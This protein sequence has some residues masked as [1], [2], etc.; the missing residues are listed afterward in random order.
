M[1]LNTVN[2]RL[3]PLRLGFLVKP[4]DGRSLRNA[5]Q[6]NTCLWGGSYNP[7]VPAYTRLTKK[8]KGNYSYT[9]STR[10]IVQGFI[11]AF[12]ADFVVLSKGVTYEEHNGGPKPIHSTNAILSGFAEN[13]TP[14]YG[15]GIFEILKDLYET[16]FR[17]VLRDSHEPELIIPKIE[18]PFSLFKASVFGEFP[19]HVSTIFWKENA[20]SFKAT[21]KEITAQTFSDL[22]KNSVLFPRRLVSRRIEFPD[23]KGLINDSIIFYMDAESLTDIIDYWNL[24]ACGARVLP[25]P[26]QWA[27]EEKVINL[28]SQFI[29]HEFLQYPSNPNTFHFTLIITGRSITHKTVRT[30]TEQLKISKA[31]SNTFKFVIQPWYPPIWQEPTPFVEQLTPVSLS[32]DETSHSIDLTQDYVELP[33]LAPKF[34]SEFG[35]HR[36]PR[37][38]NEISYS[39]YSQETFHAESYPRSSDQIRKEI[40]YLNPS[41]FRLGKDG[42]V[43]LAKQANWAILLKTPHAENVFFAWLRD[44]GFQANISAAGKIMRQILR[45]S[46]GLDGV[47]IL[48]NI[49]LV[50]LLD[51]LSGG[52][53]RPFSHAAP[54]KK[55]ETTRE[56]SDDYFLSRYL[57][58]PEAKSLLK[59]IAKHH[60]LRLLNQEQLYDRLVE[61]KAFRLGLNLN[62]PHCS[63]TSW[64][65]VDDLTDFVDC[66]QCLQN[67]ELIRN[68]PSSN[69]PW[70]LRTGGPYSLPKYAD[71]AYTSLLALHFFNRNIRFELK[72]TPVES[73]N[74]KPIHQ[75]TSIEVDFGFLATENALGVSSSFTLFGECKTHGPFKKKDL[76]RMRTLAHYFPGSILAFCT[77]DEDFSDNEKRMLRG[78]V[79]AR[80]QYWRRDR[81]RNPVILLTRVELMSFNPPPYAWQEKGGKWKAF[82]KKNSHLSGI[83]DL[84]DATQQLYLDLD[85][86]S[87]AIK[88]H[89]KTIIARRTKAT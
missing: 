36:V 41:D 39:L 13:R 64:T 53:K 79:N 51:W 6:V 46:K 22:L 3:R 65:S 50:H 16:E 42:P 81:P 18:P 86:W 4:T 24:R 66:P 43:Y 70:S 78:F 34:A 31:P 45:L 84:C 23:L 76:D 25:I 17:Y 58:L 19:L 48:G 12:D 9:G 44:K 56:I 47:A 14:N 71:G 68:I 1:A 57:P 5:I 55:K 77:L 87:E 69:T 28:A 75:D 7:I 49:H 72:M 35:G 61:M 40:A 2:I 26:H 89:Y 37:F 10:Q 33:V 59:E 80:R 8:W 27:A 32:S 38:A 73:F 60:K 85:P 29:E 62:C 15:V 30:F 21:R 88:D 83:F 54:A 67:Y 82:A 63:R 20:K 52:V 11:D 74:M